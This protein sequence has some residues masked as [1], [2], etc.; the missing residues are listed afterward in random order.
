MNPFKVLSLCG[1]NEL[2]LRVDCRAQG[3]VWVVFVYY[4]GVHRRG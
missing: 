3:L 1:V 4:I 2:E